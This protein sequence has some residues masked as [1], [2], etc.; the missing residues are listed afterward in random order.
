MNAHRKNLIALALMCYFVVF[1]AARYQ[2][3]R[4]LVGA[5]FDFLP[6]LVVVAAM[7]H[8]M[9]AVFV[10]AGV[11]GVLFDSLSANPL[12]VT[13]LAL[14]AVGTFVYF[15]RELLLRDQVYPQ[16]IVGAG[17]SAS[18]PILSYI[19]ATALGAHPLVDWSSLWAWLM[20]TLMGG[21]A[22]PVWFAVFRR[23][24]RALHYQV[25]PESSYRGDR[26]IVRGRN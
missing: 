8:G 23:V 18:A 24:D 7:M 21:L 22:T 16:F 19:C 26:E 14:C 3:V 25:I 15:N 11:G 6:G 20:M 4:I 5:Q 9:T 13:T 12:G 10:V 17:A 2:G 1:L